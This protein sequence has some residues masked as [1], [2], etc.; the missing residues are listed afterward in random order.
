M[1]VDGKFLAVDGKSN[2]DGKSPLYRDRPPVRYFYVGK[3]TEHRPGNLCRCRR[4]SLPTMGGW[5]GLLTLTVT[6]FA[7]LL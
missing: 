5:D 2:F 1:R 3:I 6:Y 7:V 4:I